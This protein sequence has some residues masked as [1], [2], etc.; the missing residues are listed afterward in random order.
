MIILKNKI[1]LSFFNILSILTI[2]GTI[3]LVISIL[4]TFALTFNSEPEFTL[5]SVTIEKAQENDTLKP[6]DSE[7]WYKVTYD[8]SVSSHKF[9]PYSY[10]VDGFALKAPADFR[11]NGTYKLY[12]DEALSFSN[13]QKDDF[14]LILYI[15]SSQGIEYIKSIVQNSGFGTRGLTQKFSF[16]KYEPFTDMPGFYISDFE[17]ANIIVR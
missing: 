10:D 4:V 15:E 14:T 16:F 5:N 13:T 12:L 1:H 17:N 3:S 9:S 6:T 8:M 2:I 11:R 7:N